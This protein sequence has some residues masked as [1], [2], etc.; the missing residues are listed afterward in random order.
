MGTT[1]DIVRNVYSDE[2]KWTP[3]N[4]VPGT[5][6]KDFDEWLDSVKR[7]AVRDFIDEQNAEYRKTLGKIMY[8][9]IDE[10]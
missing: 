5:W 9:V 4:Y 8:S 6:A 7:Q 3:L 2:S 10:V 1:T